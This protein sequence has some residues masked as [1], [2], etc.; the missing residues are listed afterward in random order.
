MT[1]DIKENVLVIYGYD[2]LVAHLMTDDGE[3]D[4]DSDV[5]A[6]FLEGLAPYL[7]EPL[8]IQAIENEKCCFPIVAQELKIYPDGQIEYNSFKFGQ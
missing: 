8:I 2:V 5:T 1:V 3:A 6:E 7:A 4:P